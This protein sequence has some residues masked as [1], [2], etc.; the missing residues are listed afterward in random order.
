M[1][2]W[3]LIPL[4]FFLLGILGTNLELQRVKKE[5]EQLKKSKK[6]NKK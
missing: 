1:E 3:V 5:L 6:K 2:L 4:T